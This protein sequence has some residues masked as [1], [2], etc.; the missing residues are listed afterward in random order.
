MPRP[1]L[2]PGYG[3]ILYVNGGYITSKLNPLDVDVAIRSDVWD[4]SRFAAAFSA[5][6]PGE[7]AL[8]DF[9][10][11]PQQSAQQMEDRFR[12]IQESN[13]KEGI[14]RLIP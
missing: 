8:V 7:E 4:D 3:A 1:H 5:A 11:N 10:F 6:Y 13:A 12:D 9:C 14:I 2:V